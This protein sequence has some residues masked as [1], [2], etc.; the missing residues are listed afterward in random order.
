MNTERIITE[1]GRRRVVMDE[2]DYQSLIDARD[3]AVEMRDI[4]A[5]TPTFSDIELDDYLAAASPPGLL[6]PTRRAEPKLP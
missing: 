1:D 4:A 6:V 3:P 2:A 5:G